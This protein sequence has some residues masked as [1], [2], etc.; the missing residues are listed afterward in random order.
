MMEASS[1]RAQ[2]VRRRLG[3]PVLQIIHLLISA[4]AWVIFVSAYALSAAVFL[5]WGWFVVDAVLL[6][7]PASPKEL[8]HALLLAIELLILVPAPALVGMVAY[9]TLVQISQPHEPDLAISEHQLKVA[10]SLLVGLLIS[11]TGMTLLDSLFTDSA[12]LELFLCGGLLIAVLAG[13][14]MVYKIR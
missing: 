7:T 1:T 13:V 6:T 10:E 5:H 12:T 14:M 11:V 8:I 3:N 9:K 4:T 2:R